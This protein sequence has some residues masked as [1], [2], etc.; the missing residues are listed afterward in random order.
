MLSKVSSKLK[1]FATGKI[2]FSLLALLVIFS[3]FLV[4]SA[5][6]KLGSISGD[7]GFIDLLFAYTPETVLSMMGS[8]GDEGRSFYKNF[9]PT[10]DL[11]YPIIYSLFLALL[12]AFLFKKSL[13][14][15][16]K[17]HYLSVV[18]L[19]SWIFDWLENIN[20]LIML[21]SYP[22]F[23]PVIANLSSI[24]TSV[25][26]SFSAISAVILLIALT[27]FIK[28]KVHKFSKK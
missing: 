28:N 20:I 3:A 9:T 12:I 6:E 8:Y 5:G 14:A 15:K 11:F 25:K 26:W 10:I 4:P 21:Y 19:F 2:I 27:L 23:P 13:P 16:S 24:F 7:V 18:P 1:R 17:M 22:K